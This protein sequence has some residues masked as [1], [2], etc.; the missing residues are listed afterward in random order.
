MEHA[1][2][3]RYAVLLMRLVLGGSLSDGSLTDGD[4]SMDR[5]RR[6]AIVAR[7]R[8]QWDDEELLEIICHHLRSKGLHKS[9]AALEQEA[10]LRL[11]GP[12]PHQL[13]LFGH[14]GDSDSEVLSPPAPRV[15]TASASAAS[16]AEPSTPSLRLCK[17]QT[18]SSSL[19]NTPKVSMC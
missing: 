1:E 9:A 19:R 2:F 5:V 14:D 7:T 17:P 18:P 12:V 3:C 11:G 16:S 13:P 10:H 6:A 15:S 4:M 8:I